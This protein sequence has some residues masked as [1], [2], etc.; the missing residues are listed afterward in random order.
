MKNRYVRELCFSVLLGFGSL[1]SLE[2]HAQEEKSEES[3]TLPG[4]GAQRLSPNEKLE[5]AKAEAK[6]EVV[7]YSDYW[8][9]LTSVEVQSPGFQDATG[10]LNIGGRYVGPRFQVM[11]LLRSAPQTVAEYSRMSS[12]VGAIALA[13]S[14]AP[15]GAVAEVAYY[16]NSG[17][18]CPKT[19]FKDGACQ[20]NTRRAFRFGL[21][22]GAEWGMRNVE[23][24]AETLADGTELPSV[25]LGST[26]GIRTFF[27]LT[28]LGAPLSGDMALRFTADVTARTLALTNSELRIAADTTQQ[29][30][31]GGD[32]GVHFRYKTAELGMTLALVY[33]RDDVEGLTGANFVPSALFSM[34]LDSPGTKLTKGVKKEAGTAA[35]DPTPEVTT[36]EASSGEGE[37][38]A[39]AEAVGDEEPI[40]GGDVA[41]GGEDV[42]AAEEEAAP[43]SQDE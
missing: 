35:G 24:K 11:G 2:A 4:G 34:P 23:L 9:L 25:E 21:R 20:N 33:G 15:V 38:P 31:Y 22:T 12:E 13:P 3:V 26:V 16:F 10:V 36:A 1:A 8:S 5:A 17:I 7:R 6:G 27:G 14:L 19:D 29:T 28:A 37:G 43:A 39:A 42:V 18:Y 41:T 32:F 40:A 30:Y